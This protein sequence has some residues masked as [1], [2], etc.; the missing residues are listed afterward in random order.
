MKEKEA[1]MGEPG[2]WDDR[3]KSQEVVSEVSRIKRTIE[4]FKEVKSRVEDFSVLIEMAESQ[5]DEESLNEVEREYSDIDKVIGK[6]EFTAM[7]SGEHDHLGASLQ[8]NSGAGGTDASDWAEML[9]RMYQR[10]A[11]Q[12]GLSSRMVDISPNEE[13]GIKSATIMITGDNAY[14]YLRGERGVHRLVRISPFNAEGKRQTAFASVDVTPDLGDDSI[15]IEIDENEVEI[16]TTKAGGK[17]GQNVNKVETA[18]ILK[19]KPS[20]IIIRSS[21]QRSQHSNRDTAWALLRA[22]LYQMEEDKRR[23]KMDAAYGQKMDAAFGS[24]IRNYFLHP[25]QRVKDTRS[26]WETG[27][28]NRFLD[29]DLDECMESVLRSEK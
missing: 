27:D 8:V 20:G 22:R 12:K 5:G 13:A 4:P 18:V 15:D 24:Q 16:V 28:F 17:G 14:G 25:S 7:L 6:L 21:S 23:A 3:E 11:E 2:F 26:G 9:L 1:I 19:H 10:W 29:G